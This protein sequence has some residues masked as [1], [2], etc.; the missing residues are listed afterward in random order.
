MLKGA[1]VLGDRTRLERFESEECSNVSSSLIVYQCTVYPFLVGFDL[2]NGDGSPARYLSCLP[3]DSH[4]Q[5][6]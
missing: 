6:M 3:N 5:V 1:G 2:T 4:F